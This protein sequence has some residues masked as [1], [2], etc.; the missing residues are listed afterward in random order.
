MTAKLD[1]RLVPDM[2]PDDTIAKVKAHLAKRGFGDLEVNVN[3][4]VNYTSST[5][6]DASLTQAQ[7]ALYRRYGIDPLLFPRS[8][9]SWPGSVFTGPPL[10]LPAGFFGLGYGDGAH[11]PNEFML[12]EPN[13]PKVSGI[14]GAVRSFVDC[15]YELAPVSSLVPGEKSRGK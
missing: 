13:N 15:L 8:G 3:G 6:A 10:A 11:A 5:S 4:G 2:T 12:I 14:D 9:G 7:L 1:I